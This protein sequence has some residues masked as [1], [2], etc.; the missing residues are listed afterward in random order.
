MICNFL[1]VQVHFVFCRVLFPFLINYYHI[2]FIIIV[3]R[4]GSHKL[5]SCFF[6]CLSQ[7]IRLLAWGR[8]NNGEL[9]GIIF[10]Y[11]IPFCFLLTEF[12][13][14]FSISY[15]VLTCYVYYYCI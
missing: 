11:S 5:V 14:A 9:G 2:L 10:D 4:L 13:Y 7:M 8:V 15:I 12:N 1:I 6:Y 3:I